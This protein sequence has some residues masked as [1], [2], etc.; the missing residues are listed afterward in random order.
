MKRVLFATLGYSLAT[1][2]I[3]APWHLVIFKELYHGL[4]IYNRAEPI[5]P[6]GFLSMLIQGVVMGVI[7]P[8]YHKAG[9]HYKEATI[10]SLLMGAFLFSISTLANAA[11][12]EVASM[13]TWL[14]IQTAFHLIQFTVAGLV[15]GLIFSKCEGGRGQR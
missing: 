3:A 4:G 5:I 12:I 11:K 9:S 10:F 7:Y 8:R 1:F 13:S 14:A 15:F 2:A 6:L